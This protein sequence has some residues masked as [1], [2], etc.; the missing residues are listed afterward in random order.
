MVEKTKREDGLMIRRVVINPKV[1]VKKR[2]VNQ[3][4][5]KS[6]FVDMSSSMSYQGIINPNQ[7]N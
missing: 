2:R 7:I 3:G 6:I 5:M 4:K 1:M